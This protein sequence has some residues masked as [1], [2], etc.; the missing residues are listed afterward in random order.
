MTQKELISVATKQ[1]D[2]DALYASGYGAKYPDTWVVRWV[3]RAFPK[4][5]PGPIPTIADLGCGAGAT[6]WYLMR[7]GFIARGVDYSNEAIRR[8]NQRAHRERWPYVRASK[9]SFVNLPYLDGDIDGAIDNCSLTHLESLSDYRDALREVA[10]ILGNGGRFLHVA[11]G[12]GTNHPAVLSKSP[13][14]KFDRALMTHA[15]EVAGLTVLDF[16]TITIQR[17]D[18]VIEMLLA[19]C[20]KRA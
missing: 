4:P 7:E 2:W 8:V 20:Q 6:L 1:V 15:L 13:V 17:S 18:G 14:L 16:E 11:F 12:Y 19:D 9:A 3:S 10:R 5:F